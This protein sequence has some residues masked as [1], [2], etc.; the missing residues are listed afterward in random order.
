M[1]YAHKNLS[2]KKMNKIL[3]DIPKYQP[4][5][6]NLLKKELYTYYPNF[7]FKDFVW[8]ECITGWHAKEQNPPQV[9]IPLV[10]IELIIKY[11][12]NEIPYNQ[13][14]QSLSSFF[15]EMG[16]IHH[17][18]SSCLPEE[19]ILESERIADMFVPNNLDFLT[20]TKQTFEYYQKNKRYYCEDAEHPSHQERINTAN[21]R[22]V[23]LLSYLTVLKTNTSQLTPRKALFTWGPAEL[24][25]QKT[26]DEFKTNIPYPRSCPTEYKDA[27]VILKDMPP[28][29]IIIKDN[30][31]NNEA[32]MSYD[33]ALQS[34]VLHNYIQSIAMPLHNRKEAQT[35]AIPFDKIIPS[36]DVSIDD[37]KDLV[38]VMATASKFMIENRYDYKTTKREVMKEIS[39][40]QTQEADKFSKIHE[41]SKILQVPYVTQAYNKLLAGK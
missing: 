40:L 6:D 4:Q 16:H 7:K 34:N 5:I 33:V 14:Y 26:H 9:L 22:I 38:P 11:L 18:H 10:D 20:A 21:S 39:H 36:S 8:K 13:L 2:L 35:L 28:L 32:K 1:L 12:K 15:H 30:Q 3:S 37:I 19:K 25:S 23:N 31:T 29:T 41:I 24:T 17:Q 27:V